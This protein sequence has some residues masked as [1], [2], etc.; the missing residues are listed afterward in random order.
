M[1]WKR[2]GS[3]ACP[4]PAQGVLSASVC[5][6]RALRMRIWGAVAACTEG[7][8]RACLSDA[9]RRFHPPRSRT[10]RQKTSEW[11]GRQERDGARNMAFA[12]HR[13]TRCSTSGS[14][15]GGTW[16]STA[17]RTACRRTQGVLAPSPL[18]VQ[19]LDAWSRHI[20]RRARE[21]DAIGERSG[22]V[23]TCGERHRARVKRGQP[24]LGVRIARSVVP[25]LFSFWGAVVS[26]FTAAWDFLLAAVTLAACDAF[27][28]SCCVDGLEGQLRVLDV[29]LE[30]LQGPNAALVRHA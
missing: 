26:S 12:V 8:C 9:W 27:E 30:Q 22:E 7:R 2:H 21:R 16:C 23:W 19:R 11:V 13:C 29:R 4:F 6:N 18:M 14:V 28:W 17:T 10:G 25:S 24:W 20:K 1:S 3:P 5:E 15:D